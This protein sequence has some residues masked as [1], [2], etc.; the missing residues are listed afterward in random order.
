MVIYKAQNNNSNEE[1]DFNG[2][3][4][5]QSESPEEEGSKY[6]YISVRDED[7]S[8]SKYNSV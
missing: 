4:M 1:I 7:A 8:S 6:K 2:L 3:Y 5:Q